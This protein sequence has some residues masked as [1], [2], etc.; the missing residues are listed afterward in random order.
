[1]HKELAKFTNKILMFIALVVLVGCNAQSGGA[2]DDPDA[3]QGTGAGLVYLVN[4]IVNGEAS[5]NYEE[6]SVSRKITN[7]TSLS[8]DCS[9]ELLTTNTFSTTALP[10]FSVF[11]EDD[12]TSIPLET[13]NGGWTYPLGSDAFYQ[14]STFFHVKKMMDNVLDSLS[15]A[16]YS[17]FYN[18]LT[19]SIPSAT[20]FYLPTTQ[21]F[22]LT[23]N[24][25][26]KTL[27]VISKCYL[28][29]DNF[30]AFYSA[31]ESE[32]CFGYNENIT[33]LRFAQD[34]SVIYHEL[35]HVFV[36]ILLN[37]RN[38]FMN[39]NGIT[40]E[41]IPYRVNLGKFS[42][43]EGGALNEGI[44]DFFAYYMNRRTRFG[45]WAL[46][47]FFDAS[48]P[49]TES[50]PLH[51][52]T[53]TD[54]EKLS[55]P[56]HVHYDANFEIGER[57]PAKESRHNAG[58]ITSHYLV[59]LHKQLQSTC[60]FP[61]NTTGLSTTDYK[62]KKAND[63]LIYLLS[64]TLGELGDQ[65]TKGSDFYENLNVSFVNLNPE[66][67]YEWNDSKDSITYRKFYKTFAKNIYHN[68]S[69]YLC[70]SFT[71]E[72]SESLLDKYGLLLFKNYTDEGSGRNIASSQSI[73]YDDIN[74]SATHPAT[75]S[76]VALISPTTSTKVDEIYRNNSIL[77]SKELIGLPSST[78]GINRAYLIDDKVQIDRL[79]TNL[80]YQG[81]PVSTSTGVA[82]T[83]FNNSNIQIGPGEIVGLSLN[84]VNNSNSIMAG[85]E[86]LGNDWDHM[87]LLNNSNRYVNRFSNENTF[88]SSQLAEH[89][90]CQ[91]NGFP[92]LTEGALTDTTENQGDCSFN[93][94]DNNRF[95]FEVTDTNGKFPMHSLDSPQPIC[96]VRHQADDEE[97]W[98]SQNFK[99]K[100][101]GIGDT[102]CLDYANSGSSF[103][104]NSCLV[105]VLPGASNAIYSKIDPGQTLA[106][107]LS[108]DGSVYE[109]TSSNVVL[110]EINKRIPPGL[111]FTCRFRARMSNC[112]DCFTDENGNEYTQSDYTSHQPFKVIDFTFA[113]TE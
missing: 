12:S 43:D 97:R 56:R 74:A 59:A 51:T 71:K 46:G 58:Q 75:G 89:R 7:N 37:Q 68:I 100:D 109:V 40:V 64:E 105:R 102:D 9:F 31:A 92:L 6:N 8:E 65:T 21:S 20:N 110:L 28:D 13:S 86:V 49:L 76:A 45:E 32:L 85:L 98:V 101:L 54:T 93:S 90:P 111:E 17:A 79:L 57:N 88:R 35:G 66:N 24:T 107:T 15:F 67:A 29:E 16:H 5:P 23:E 4:P 2:I 36:D 11:N 48:R 22:W 72:Q 69:Q 95:D 70:P 55:Y 44:A 73:I 78:S 41:T 113:V 108:S 18:R 63:Y 52:A 27:R 39:P 50:D 61:T 84:I 77:I 99:R 83:E 30:N 26:T 94:K 38:T 33:S 96:L 34:P 87:K 62:H 10:C 47:R 82:G 25:I 3:F 42:Y 53:F 80:T 60:S 19:W 103:N 91:I 14:V 112:S 1:M 106:D 81:V 104:P